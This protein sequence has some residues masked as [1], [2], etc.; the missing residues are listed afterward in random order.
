MSGSLGLAALLDARRSVVPVEVQHR[1][2][3]RSRDYW[4]YDQRSEC[5]R[6]LKGP[7]HLPLAVLARTHHANIGSVPWDKSQLN[8]LYQR[9]E[10]GG[11]E[12]EE[13]ALMLGRGDA[14]AELELNFRS[15]PEAFFKIVSLD[16]ESYECFGSPTL[17]DEDRA[18]RSRAGFPATPI[19]LKD[20]YSITAESLKFD[21][22]HRGRSVPL[23]ADL[24]CDWDEVRV[25]AQKW[26]D[27]VS[28]YQK[29]KADYESKQ[30]AIPDLWSLKKQTDF[31]KASF[32]DMASQAD[33]KSDERNQIASALRSVLGEITACDE[34]T[35]ENLANIE[36]H[37]TD[38]KEASER[39]GP[40]DWKM[41]FLG[42]ITT[43]LVTDA[44]PQRVVQTI[45]TSVVAALGH[46]LGMGTPPHLLV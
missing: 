1:G 42:V 19:S 35:A 20:F 2:R 7:T 9:I 16:P 23:A 44:I 38:L 5:W 8:D 12:P 18:Q 37:L 40:K 4:S 24:L 10:A 34:L 15:S 29:A 13:C 22:L 41:M 26:S 17:N 31:T 27:G 3:G 25:I 6:P 45:Y 11:L 30:A 32:S 21:Y 46:V 28:Q 39:V 36:Q 33:F 14:E 43:M